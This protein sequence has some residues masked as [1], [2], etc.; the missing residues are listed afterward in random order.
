MDGSELEA[1]K[2]ARG[3]LLNLEDLEDSCLSELFIFTD[4]EVEIPFSGLLL[5]QKSTFPA[6][7]RVL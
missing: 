5:M 4:G 2:L 1:S 7:S 3:S 6:S